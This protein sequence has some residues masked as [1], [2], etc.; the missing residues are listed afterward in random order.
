MRQHLPA[1]TRATVSPMANETGLQKRKVCVFAFDEDKGAAQRF[2]GLLGVPLSIIE[3]RSFPDG[4]SLTRLSDYAETAIVFRPL[5]DPN[6]KLI[7]IVLAASALA[8][9]GS[10]QRILVAPYLGYMRQDIAFHPGEAVSQRVIGALLGD[11]FEAFVTADPHLHRTPLLETVFGGKPT[12]SVS[13]ARLIGEAVASRF[14]DGNTIVIGPDEE[15]TPLTK[16]AAASA[17][18]PWTVG[19]KVRHGDR[20]VE[21]VLPEDAPIAGRNAIIVDDVISSG[22]TIIACTET[23]LKR[24]AIAVHAYA[25]HALCSSQ[26]LDAMTKAG[27][28]SIVSCD[29]VSHA[30]NGIAL[31]PLL[32]EAVRPWL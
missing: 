17:K 31:A 12:V 27:V 24:G 18:T 3:R 13:A 23:S 6:T 16:A 32:A 20:A 28:T 10:T 29:S 2:A 1:Q 25:T 21:L 26:D 30:T 22:T 8:D 19:T 7:E 9:G 11:A 4:E 14:L 5:H 15:S